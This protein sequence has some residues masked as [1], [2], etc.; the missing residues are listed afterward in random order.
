MK[1][2]ED[3]I[4]SENAINSGIDTVVVHDSNGE[5][6]ESQIIGMTVSMNDKK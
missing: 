3:Q 5:K 2:N 4:N 6:V 1:V